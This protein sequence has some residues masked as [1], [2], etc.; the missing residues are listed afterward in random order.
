MPPTP[1]DDGH[2]HHDVFQTPFLNTSNLEETPSEHHLKRTV[3]VRNSFT[4][5]P[6][7]TTQHY[8]L[9]AASEQAQHYINLS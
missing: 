5:N 8:S 4:N 7:Y 6:L 3:K 9:S 2:A 1:P